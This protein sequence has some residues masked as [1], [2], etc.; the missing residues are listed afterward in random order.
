M[1][2]TGMQP[3]DATEAVAE[4]TPVRIAVWAAWLAAMAPAVVSLT[5]VDLSYFRWL[6]IPSGVFWAGWI[7]ALVAI[8][9]PFAA[10]WWVAE[11]PQAGLACLLLTV[12]F[13]GALM[14]RA[15]LALL[16]AL[17]LLALIL[18]APVPRLASGAAALA[19]LALSIPQGWRRALHGRREP[20]RLVPRGGAIRSLATVLVSSVARPLLGLRVVSSAIVF[21]GIAGLMISVNDFAA[22]A[23]IAT[24]AGAVALGGV[25]IAAHVGTRTVTQWHELR[26]L[27]RSIS[28]APPTETAALLACVAGASAVSSAAIGLTAALL[29][30][31]SAKLTLIALA[32]GCG[33]GIAITC[34]AVAGAS[35]QRQ[36][37]SVLRGWVAALVP[38]AGLVFLLAAVG[39]LALIMLPAA[40]IVSASQIYEAAKETVA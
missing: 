22:E 23:T 7:A 28:V 39:T 20:L 17:A 6:P 34:L 8:N 35:R 13:H 18:I 24:I 37:D 30:G 21:G 3:A 16:L 4:S 38:A 5:R 36:K 9:L 26:W 1:G 2:P 25:G 11:G 33:C 12:A 29:A 32:A 27:L 31:L 15:M 10:F 40:L 19:S 14:A